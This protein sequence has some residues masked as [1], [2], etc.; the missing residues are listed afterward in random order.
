VNPDGTLTDSAKNVL[1]LLRQPL[2]AQELAA[3]LNAPLF[4]VRMSLRELVAAGLLRS[5]GARYVITSAGSE[6]LPTA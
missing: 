6:K 4:W 3:R 1:D 2:T 5:E